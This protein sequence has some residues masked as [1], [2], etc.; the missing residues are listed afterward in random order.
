MLFNG[1]IIYEISKDK[2]GNTNLCDDIIQYEISRYLNVREIVRMRRINRKIKN[3][4]H[5]LM[6]T[7]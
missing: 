2:M 1:I 5:D 6:I 4:I 7:I 3:I